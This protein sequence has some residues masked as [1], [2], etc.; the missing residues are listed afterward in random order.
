[1]VPGLVLL[2]GDDADTARGTSLLVVI[3]TALTAT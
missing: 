3:F 2:T 1:M